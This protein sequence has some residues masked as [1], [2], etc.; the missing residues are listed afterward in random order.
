MTPEQKEI[1]DTINSS[2]EHLLN[3]I[4]DILDISKIE[5]GRVELD[6]QP[7]D[8][9]QL[10]QEISSLISIRTN[11]KGL[12]F[13]FEHPPDFPRYITMDGPKLR[14][15]LINLIG[16]AVKYTARGSVNV[17]IAASPIPEARR[18]P[19]SNAS[20]LL[21]FT[22]QDTGPGIALKDRTRIFMP[23]IQLEDRSTIE[24]GAGLGLALCKQYTELMGG[25]IRLTGEPGKGSV[26][27]LEIPVTALP[28]AA[29]L[30]TKQ[31]GRV[32]GLKEGQ[33][34]YRLLIA[35]DRVENRMLL[36]NLLRPLGF[37]LREATNGLEAVTI[38]KEWHPHL[39]WMD[40]R[41]PVMNGLE[42]TRQIKAVDFK[43]PT[44]IIAVTAHA[45]DEERQEILA[46][47]CHDLISKPYRDVEI[48]DSLTKHL[49][50]HFAYENESLPAT[51]V[52]PVNETVLHN[53]PQE[54]LHSLELALSRLDI[55]AVNKAIEAIRV[56]H[57]ALA[58][59]L[60][61]IAY[62]L[63]FGRLLRL[64]RAMPKDPIL[65]G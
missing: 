7:L 11:E 58:D 37:D 9:Q 42:A 36:R 16:N 53:L 35:E 1:L 60:A 38:F 30:H 43:T 39:I 29:I 31:R 52:S 49:G 63:Q 21:K 22:I 33:P 34:L 55:K 20:F 23:F 18:D 8:L 15:I 65:K 3:L 50:V 41:M 57:P 62:D 54:L 14:Q 51:D 64:I 46:A 47:G 17:K 32:I 13:T 4:N 28:S 56:Q 48:Y 40:I 12:E 6:E 24:G 44:R 26:F 25:V 10:I 5:A 61:I 2:G 59:S 19:K 45:L 27:D